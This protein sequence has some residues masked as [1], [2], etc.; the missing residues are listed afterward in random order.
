MMASDPLSVP[1][2]RRFPY[3]VIS[4]LS[5]CQCVNGYTRMSLFPYVGFMV[6]HLLTLS[7]DE[8]GEM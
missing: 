7:T 6:K 8:V 5:L 4:I 3:M 2:E 1:K